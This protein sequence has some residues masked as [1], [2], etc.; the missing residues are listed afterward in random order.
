M[1]ES[2]PY[3][4]FPLAKPQAGT[5]L[6]SGTVQ[7]SV[8]IP[9]PSDTVWTAITRRDEVRKWFGDLSA[10]LKPGGAARLDFGDGDFFEIADAALDPPHIL[11]YQWRFL[12]TGPSNT[13]EW[14]SVAEDGGVRLTVTDC[15]P[16]RTAAMVDELTEGWTDFLRRLQVHGASGQNTRYTW[17]RQ[18]DGSVELAAEPEAAYALLFAAEGQARW[19]PWVGEIAHKARVS[20]IDDR[21]PNEFEIG[22][23]ERPTPLSLRFDFGCLQWHSRTSCELQIQPRLQGSLLVVSHG[24][25]EGIS[26]SENERGGERRRFGELWIEALRR[27]KMQAGD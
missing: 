4:S 19:L 1:K 15:E 7:V 5:N 14:L 17:R 9:A 20:M 3:A 10:D 2:V 24:G 16:D 13:I 27:A 21:K 8:F 26:D 12:G 22:D 18:F 23:V 25:W 6:P 11:Q